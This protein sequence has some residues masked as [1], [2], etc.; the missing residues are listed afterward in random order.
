MVQKMDNAR[1]ALIESW[2]AEVDVGNDV[3]EAESS[4]DEEID[5]LEEEDHQSESEQ[6]QDIPGEGSDESSEED[7]PPQQRRRRTDFYRG[8]DDTLWSKTVPLNRGRTRSHNIVFV[9]PGPKGTARQ[10]TTLEDCMSLFFDDHIIHLITKYTNKKIDYIKEKYRRERDAKQTNETEI[11]GYIGILLM[12][13]VVGKRKSTAII[14]EHPVLG[15]NMNIT[16][17]NWF[18]SL[19]T[20]KQLFENGT[21]M[22]GTVRKDKREVPREFRVARG[23]PLHSSKFGRRESLIDLSLA[24]MKPLAQKRLEKKRCQEHSQ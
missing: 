10:K 18:S 13:G 19:R 1:D 6:E 3:Y 12:A 8:V 17:D 11:R 15:K 20:A 4:S 2:L 21:T 5:N 16:M 9:P 22:V 23:N 7:N 14:F 24:W